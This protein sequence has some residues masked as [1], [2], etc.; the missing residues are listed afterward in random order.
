MV[1]YEESLEP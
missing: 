1:H